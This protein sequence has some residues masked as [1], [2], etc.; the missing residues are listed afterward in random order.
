VVLNDSRYIN[1]WWIVRH[2]Y[3]LIHT[4][5]WPT[6]PGVPHAVAMAPDSSVLERPKSLTIILASSAVLLKRRFSGWR[7]TQDTGEN[8]FTCMH[9]CTQFSQARCDSGLLYIWQ[10][11]Y[12]MYGSLLNTFPQNRLSRLWL[13]HPVEQCKCSH[14][15][16]KTV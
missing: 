1:W 10:I 2:S 9:S 16:S 6:Y 11:Y 15:I 14:L 3:C 13:C 7:Q 5:Y 4:I 8:M 12:A